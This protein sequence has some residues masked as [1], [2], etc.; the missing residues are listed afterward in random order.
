MLDAENN[1][2]KRMWLYSCLMRKT[3]TGRGCYCELMLDAENKD[4]NWG[5][6]CYCE[7]MLDA[8]NK[9]RKR[10]L[11]LTH[12]WCRKQEQEDGVINSCLM[13]RTRMGRGCY[14]WLMLDA[15]NKDRKRVLFIVD[16]CLMQRPGTGRG[17]YC[18][19]MRAEENKDRS[20][21]LLWTRTWW[22]GQ[23]QECSVIVDSQLLKTRAGV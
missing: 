1:D 7:L 17:C 6:G 14:C 4:R 19:L 5:R 9:D 20:V 15:E 11:L 22:R 12:A 3:R 16:L 18:E 13:Q 23:G 21:V 2:R 10:V 8:E